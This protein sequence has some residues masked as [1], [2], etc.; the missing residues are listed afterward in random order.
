MFQ[1]IINQKLGSPRG[2]TQIKIQ[3]KIT[4]IKNTYNTL[5]L[6]IHQQPQS[7]MC[8]HPIYCQTSSVVDG[9]LHRGDSLF[10]K[11]YFD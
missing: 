2:G 11:A 1:K 4:T 8:G 5:G 9:M 10:T 7:V 6:S 3:E